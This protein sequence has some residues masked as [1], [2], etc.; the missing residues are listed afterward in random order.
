MNFLYIL[1]TSSNDLYIGITRELPQ[2]IWRHN[3]GKGAE[4]IKTHR[5]ATLVYSEK[6]PDI[7]STRR[8]ENQIKRWSRAKK[9]ALI[10]GN[11]VVLK[12]LSRCRA[13]SQ[14]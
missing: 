6:H 9:E 4:W 7:S 8:R 11:L 12:A 14:Q 5:N 10:A 3:V 1:R 2:R 13:R